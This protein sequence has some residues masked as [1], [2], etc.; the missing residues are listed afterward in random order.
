MD[1]QKK[2]NQPVLVTGA[3]GFIGRIL[4]EKLLKH[5]IQIKALVLPDEKLPPGWETNKLISVIRGSVTD[6]AA[7]E[8]AMKNVKT[9]FHLAAVVADWGDENL[10]WDIGVNGTRHVL[11]EA[12]KFD[13]KV[14]LASSIVVYGEKIGKEVCTEETDFGRTFG[15][16]GR[17]KQEQ[18]KIA[19]QYETKY[20][21]QLVVIRPANVYGPG[22]RPWVHQV[23]A[24][25]KSGSPSLI[26]GGDYNAGLVHVE[27]ITDAMVLA[28]ESEKA[29][30][31]TYNVC[32][33][34]NVTW[35][36]YF[37]D[38]AEIAGCSK[39]RSIPLFVAK[40]LA[41]SVQFLWKLFRLKIQ[42]PITLE[43]LNLVSSK[44]QIEVDKLIDHLGY[45]P[46]YPY[47][48]GIKS[49][50]TYIIEGDLC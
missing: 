42:P 23:L 7:V 11:D 15:P 45:T 29:V 44:H 30:G 13:T 18:E 27:S 9:L 46:N 3:T 4:V 8:K 48:E 37:S 50:K 35:K 19:R 36:Q 16:Y 22:S 2:I 21:L 47:E 6:P 12:I 28:A 5:E 32:D 43:S 33:L 31:N 10:F 24:T 40:P 1:T 38:L 34:N 49:L 26:N 25:L 39:P 14:I 20:N 41:H 17:V